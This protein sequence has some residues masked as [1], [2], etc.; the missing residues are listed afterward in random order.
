LTKISPRN[1]KSPGNEFICRHLCAICFL[2]LPVL[3]EG[4]LIMNEI[5]PKPA[6]VI[7]GIASFWK[8]AIIGIIILL[9]MIPV[10]WINSLVK[11]RDNRRDN[12]I[13]EI[14]SKWGSKQTI[15]GPFLCIPYQ[16]L[17]TT[18]DIDGNKTT[19]VE[20]SYLYLTPD[21]LNIKG[22]IQTIPQ[23]RGIFKTTG[24][25]AELDV[26]SVFDPE[27]NPDLFPNYT[28]PDW[29][30]ALILFDLSDQR[31]LKELT[32]TLNNNEIVF[33]ETENILRVSSFP[34]QYKKKSVP[35]SDKIINFGLEG[36]I[37]ASYQPGK[38]KLN[39]HLVLTGTG[40]M[41][42]LASAL[43]ENILL[44][45]DWPSPSFIGDLLP[46]SRTVTDK[47]FSG[48][49][50]TNYLNTGNKKSWTSQEPTVKLSSL[51][52][53]FLIMV[54]SYQQTTRTLKYSILFLLL[55]FMTFFFVETTTRQRIHPIQYLM[56]GF[57]L[58]LFYLLLLSI[59]EH[60]AFGWS[61]LIAAIGIIL[62]I[63]LY[64][65]TILKTRKFSLQVGS[66]LTILYA[67]LYVLLQLEDSALLV[68]SISLFVLLAIAMYITRNINWYNQ[69]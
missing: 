38:K 2:A 39:L 62:Q 11:E 6:T 55:T 40:S 66:V 12:V 35:D 26:T 24:Y 58:V 31:G 57:S 20:T 48:E 1:I 5:P 34:E 29:N 61:Y 46:D 30:N 3:K 67:F 42:F 18:N 47:G 53:N 56:V 43:R 51:G 25:K 28:Q 49:W 9:L 45:G 14:A 64:C 63:S 33:G 23:H 16:A 8:L 37:P 52:V 60:L 15:S 54:D 10:A 41:S 13:R 36:K 7:K 17:V 32:A 68:G 22:V 69:E 4:V 44:Q 50:Q 21:S 65:L 59:S 19:K 27:V